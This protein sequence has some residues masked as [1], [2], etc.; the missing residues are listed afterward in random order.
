MNREI[1]FRHW[2]PDANEMT[3]H[4][5]IRV[6]PGDKTFKDVFTPDIFDGVL[7]QYTG[8]K[9][10]NGAEI[11]EGDKLRDPD[12]EGYLLIVWNKEKAKFEAHQ[13]GYHM[14]FNEG[15][16]EEFNND[17]SCIDKDA[18]GMEDIYLYEV[19]GN[20]YENKDY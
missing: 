2:C 15:G 18:V 5:Q 20:I 11:Y 6:L 19:I 10:K 13:C 12:D 4:E 16:G 9:D 17:L 3:P 8:L 1:K 7:M 14:Y